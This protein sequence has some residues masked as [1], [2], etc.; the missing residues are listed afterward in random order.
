MTQQNNQI[1]KKHRSPTLERLLEKMEN[2][3]WHIKL[4]RWWRI[5]RWLWSCKLRHY[6][7]WVTSKNYR[8][9]YG[10]CDCFKGKRQIND[11]YCKDNPKCNLNKI[12]VSYIEA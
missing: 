9:S 11:D 1:P 5:R 10:D 8:L 3:P 2:D 4:K 12:C 7:H 6:F